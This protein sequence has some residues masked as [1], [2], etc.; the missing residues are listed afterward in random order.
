MPLGILLGAEVGLAGL[1]TLLNPVFWLLYGFLLLTWDRLIT[2]LSLDQWGLWL[3][4][5]AYAL[6]I[7]ALVDWQQFAASSG[8]IVR[9][10]DLDLVF[11]M[12]VA[13]SWGAFAVVWFHVLE[14]FW[15][16]AQAPEGQWPRLS[17]RWLWG[18]FVV[19]L[20]IASVG[21]VG[22]E[23]AHPFGSGNAFLIALGGVV[24]LIW[25]ARLRRRS[26]GQPAGSGQRSN[27]LIRMA[28]AIAGLQLALG[29][30][31]GPIRGLLTVAGAGFYTLAAF[32]I[33]LK[34]KVYI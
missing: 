4:A 28:L 7:S 31:A 2:R 1:P 15:P 10:A 11:V 23:T 21:A 26:T 3:L 22:S 8:T 19:F 20:L 25:L 6:V 12:L 18:A 16:R 34:K 30:V 9:V 29:L 33:L 13:M 5:M 32:I 24:L 17:T 14:T 27:W